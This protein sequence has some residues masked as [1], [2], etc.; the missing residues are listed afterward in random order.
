MAKTNKMFIK[1]DN[2]VEM[3]VNATHKTLIRYGTV[4]TDVVVPDSNVRVTHY[5]LDGNLYM[6]VMRNGDV[7]QLAN[8][9]CKDSGIIHSVQVQL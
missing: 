2:V 9:S 6:V 3:D 4:V 8:L 1:R 7:V 5:L